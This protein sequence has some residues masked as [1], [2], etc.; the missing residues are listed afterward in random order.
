MTKT[1]A[2]SDAS[3]NVR[4]TRTVDEA[5]Q[6]LGI[7]RASAYAYAKSGELPTIRM[8]NRLLVPEAM[9]EKL[10]ASA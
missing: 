2:D 5:A 7:S 9:L 3:Q 1:S 10:L 4:R 6:I 8:G